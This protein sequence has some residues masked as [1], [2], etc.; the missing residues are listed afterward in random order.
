MTFIRMNRYDFISEAEHVHC[1][2]DK[3]SREFDRLTS[4][5][6]MD[7]GLHRDDGDLV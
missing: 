5:L 2:S 3:Y 7:E 6:G 1:S 4:A